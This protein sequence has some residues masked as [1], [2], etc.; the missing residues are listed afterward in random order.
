MLPLPLGGP[1]GIVDTRQPVDWSHPLNHGRV[2]WYYGLPQWSGGSIWRDLC[3]RSDGVFASAGVSWQTGKP[4]V[5]FS[6]SSVTGNNVV[7]PRSIPHLYP[8]GSKISLYVRFY[9]ITGIG[10]GTWQQV[11]GLGSVF[12]GWGYLLVYNGTELRFYTAGAT[13]YAGVTVGKDVWLNIL[14]TYDGS[15]NRIYSL[16][17]NGVYL[18]GIGTQSGVIGGSSFIFGIGRGDHGGGNYDEGDTFGGLI[19]EVSIWSERVLTVNDHLTLAL[20]SRINR[21]PDTIRTIKPWVY[22]I[23]VT[24]PLTPPVQS[25]YYRKLSF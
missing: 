23:D 18:T 20:Q 11:A 14:A 16:S 19:P 8:S 22:G 1:V 7:I 4:I 3:R 6:G 21:Y 2:L 12:S 5:S 15:N 17:D 9:A 25:Y 13:G 10:S 24:S